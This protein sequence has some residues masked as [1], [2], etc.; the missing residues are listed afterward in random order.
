MSLNTT[1]VQRSF[2]MFEE[3]PN[4][5]VK[6]FLDIL[7]SKHP[8]LRRLFDHANVDN[9]Q[10]SFF[11]TLRLAVDHLDDLEKLE[12]HFLQVGIRHAQRGVKQKY[13]SP[14]CESMLEAMEIVA[15]DRWD[16]EMEKAWDELL[17][18]LAVIIKN[19]IR[20][21]EVSVR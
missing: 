16:D 14:V 21:S 15:G 20:Q 7:L 18:V 12:S 3:R 9:F 13:F 10:E 4:E 5:L 11:H 6:T 19:G 1:L 8:T 2:T 17:G